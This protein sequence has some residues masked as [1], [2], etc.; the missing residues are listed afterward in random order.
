M[1]EL[2]FKKDLF[3]AWFF[4]SL[5]LDVSAL[6]SPWVLAGCARAVAETASLAGQWHMCRGGEKALIA[7]VVGQGALL[8]F[9]SKKAA[10]QRKEQKNP[11]ERENKGKRIPG[12]G[13][14]VNM[15]GAKGTG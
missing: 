8:S 13:Q 2:S 10:G 6:E 7:T 15:C 5:Q 3:A 14:D 11:G 9:R 12:Q 4:T 1:G